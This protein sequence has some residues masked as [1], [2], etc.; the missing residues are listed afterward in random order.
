[1]ETELLMLATN[2]LLYVAMVIIITL[3]TKLYFPAALKRGDANSD[4]NQVTTPNSSTIIYRRM[5]DSSNVLEDDDDDHV[6]YTSEDEDDDDDGD[7]DEDDTNN[8]PDNKSTKRLVPKMEIEEDE[9][10]NITKN[11]MK[12]K[13]DDNPNNSNCSSSSGNNSNTKSGK[14]ARRCSTKAK[15]ISRKK[16]QQQ[17]QQHQQQQNNIYQFEREVATR[18][19]TVKRLALCVLMLNLTFVTW[20]FI[21][22]R[23]L[24]HPYKLHDEELQDGS[25]SPMD[26]DGI[27][28]DEGEYFEHSFALVFTNRAWTLV[29][30]GILLFYLKPKGCQSTVIYEYTFPSIS[31]MLSSWCQYEAMR[32]VSFPAVTLFKAFKLA[33]VML[34]GKVL[35]N[36]QYPQYDYFVALL[37]SIGITMFMSSTDD[38]KV[39]FDHNIYNQKETV[40]TGIMLLFFFLFFDS[41]TSQWQS[42]MFQRHR[43]LSIVE[44][45]F[46]TSA[47]SSL[48]SLISLIHSDSLW[49][50]LNFIKRHSEIHY[51]FF[52]FSICSTIGQLF[53]F[54]TIK[55]FGAVV[56][57]LIMTSRIVLSIALSCYY[58]GHEVSDVGFYG[59]VLVVGAM[60]YRIK[61]KAEGTQLIKWRGM[62]D[63]DG[64]AAKELV[65]EWHNHADM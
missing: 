52:L 63:D 17:E 47:C 58:Y 27:D 30:S 24:K 33:P 23:M 1:M 40:S 29:F 48:L 46:A 55:N 50:A 54:Y 10:S 4:Q 34:M 51:H 43:D 14:R 49:P 60:C 38:L 13:D 20:G 6:W 44:L 62:E 22:E 56:F 15:S 59:L 12:K 5:D 36:K 61:K 2:F 57:T 25:S 7:E 19:S 45:M 31:N 42:R 26:I 37:I 28:N 53:I 35:G 65:H 8:D 21:Q 11:Q 18:L 41:F 64:R 9:E 3:V 39:T 16:P 32:Y